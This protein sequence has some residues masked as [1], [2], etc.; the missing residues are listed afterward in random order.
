MSREGSTEGEYVQGGQYIRLFSKPCPN[1]NGRTESLWDEAAQSRQ[2]IL[3]SN[4]VKAKELGCP[5]ES[6]VN[7]V[8]SSSSPSLFSHPRQVGWLP[9]E[10]EATSARFGG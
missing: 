6:A 7:I 1:I 10:E 3:C 9:A 8:L 2:A 4:S 5:K